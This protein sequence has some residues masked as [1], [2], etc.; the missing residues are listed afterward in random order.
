M[1]LKDKGGKKTTY[2][3]FTVKSIGYDNEGNINQ[4]KIYNEKK[5]KVVFTLG[6]SD[7]TPVTE[8][9]QFDTQV[10][11]QLNEGI[12]V[13]EQ[14]VLKN[15]CEKKG[16]TVEKVFSKPLSQLTGKEYTEALQRISRSRNPRA[17]SNP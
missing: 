10:D 6:K 3:T 4:L 15:L 5:K 7:T 17:E 9:E 14:K 1:E 13:A 8:E 2:D 11:S 16:Y 12:S